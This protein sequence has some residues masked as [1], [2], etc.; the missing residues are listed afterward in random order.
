MK[1]TQVPTYTSKNLVLVAHMSA[2]AIQVLVVLSRSYSSVS[3]VVQS[4]QAIAAELKYLSSSAQLCATSS[5]T[6]FVSSILSPSAAAHSTNSSHAP[7]S[8]LKNLPW[9]KQVFSA[10][11]HVFVYLSSRLTS[12][13]MTKSMQAMATLSKNLSYYAQT[14]AVGVIGSGS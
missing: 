6:F 10:L 11:R 7:V 3:Q 5:Q 14:S 13:H 9:F 1:A 8:L 4:S 2:F 12:S